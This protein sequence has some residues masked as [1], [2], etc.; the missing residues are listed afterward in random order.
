MGSPVAAL[1]S[2]NMMNRLKIIIPYVCKV[3]LTPEDCHVALV[4]QIVYD[5]IDHHTRGE[6]FAP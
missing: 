4:R 2:A 5:G 1:Y 6:A 3:F